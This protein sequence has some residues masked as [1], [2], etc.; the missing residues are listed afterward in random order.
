MRRFLFQLHLWA[1]LILGLVFVALGLSGSIAMF[2]PVFHEPP[3][4]EMTAAEIPALDKALANA[5]AALG[6][7]PSVDAVIF[8]PQEADEPLRSKVFTA[9]C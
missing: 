5:R 8:L 7:A 2:W 6:V 3:A 4:V 9:I 1:G